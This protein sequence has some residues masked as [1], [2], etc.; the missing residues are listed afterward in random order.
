MVHVVERSPPENWYQIGKKFEALFLHEKS[1]K[2]EKK[3]KSVGHYTV[4]FFEFF[5]FLCRGREVRDAT[6]RGTSDVDLTGT[7]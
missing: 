6:G 1:S 5:F 3:L 2:G 7:C 4:R